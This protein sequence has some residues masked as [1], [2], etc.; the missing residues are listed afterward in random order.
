MT[1]T[2][3]TEPVETGDSVE[4]PTSFVEDSG[5][6]KEGWQDAYVPEDFRGRSIFNSVTSI[7]DVMKKM[8]NQEIVLSKGGKMVTP[9]SEEATQTEKDEFFTA[10]GRPTTAGEY[11]LTFPQ[12]LQEH[13]RPE[14][15]EASKAVFHEAGLNQKQVDVLQKF[16][17]QRITAGL[18]DMQRTAE[19]E[20]AAVKESLEQKWGVDAYNERMHFAKRAIEENTTPE[21]KDALL[22][23]IGNNQHILEFVAEISKKFKEAERIDPDGTVKSVMTKDEHLMKAK[24]LMETPGYTTGALPPA[25]MER[26]QKEIREHYAAAETP[27]TH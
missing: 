22:Q 16:E 20:Q 25:Q 1:E 19:A 15:V 10:L 21:N 18:E 11:E 24:E 23:A 8:G 2:Q 27:D 9:L 4:E 12:E 3:T 14:L 5:T 6:F 17:E 26:L 7:Q 13:I